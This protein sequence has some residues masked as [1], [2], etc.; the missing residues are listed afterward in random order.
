MKILKI[1]GVIVCVTLIILSL[2]TI[3]SLNTSEKV[4]VVKSEDILLTDEI[5]NNIKYL[6]TEDIEIAT[7]EWKSSSPV[8]L[9]SQ[10]GDSNSFGRAIA[11]NEKYLAVGDPDA[12]HVV[13]Y[14][15]NNNGEWIRSKIIEPPKDSPAY[16]IGSGFGFDL[17][18]DNNVLVISALAIKQMNKVSNTE[19]FQYKDGKTLT[20]ITIYKAIIASNLKIEYIDLNSQGLTP[21]FFVTADK[22]KIA[23]ITSKE[24]KFSKLR[25]QVNLMSDENVRYLLPSKNK[26]VYKFAGDIAIKNNLLLVGGSNS[27]HREGVWLFN[28]NKLNDLP[29]FLSISN[30]YVGGSVAIS[31]QFAA[32]SSGSRASPALLNEKPKK[33]LIRNIRNG[34]TTIIDRDG[35]ISL[36][37]NILVRSTF[38]AANRDGYSVLEIFKINDKSVPRLINK[39]ENV[40]FAQLQNGFLVT[41]KQTKHINKLCIEQLR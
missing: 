12:N 39:R 27:N 7:D 21:S 3:K 25:T 36:Y 1:S 13:V 34:H 24:K 30:A 20:S 29:L 38:Y 32:V 8:C 23:F 2:N 26:L 19:D 35:H 18:L 28:L 10:P 17:A 9:E 22:N 6:K 4:N 15:H 40:D 14:I 5:E 16:K 31:N 41:V 33:T 11:I 37:R